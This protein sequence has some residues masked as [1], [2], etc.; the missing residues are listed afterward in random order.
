M[1]AF[2]VEAKYTLSVFGCESTMASDDFQS[3]KELANIQNFCS[4]ACRALS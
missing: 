4:A 2:V 1:D 3:D